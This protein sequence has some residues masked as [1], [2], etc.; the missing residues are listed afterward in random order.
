MSGV[1]WCVSGYNLIFFCSLVSSRPFPPA[2]PPSVGS[3][4]CPPISVYT[5]AN[6]AASTP[7]PKGA[8]RNASLS[9]KKKDSLRL[10]SMRGAAGIVAKSLGGILCAL[11]VNSCVCACMKVCVHLEIHISLSH[12][13][14]LSLSLSLGV[15]LRVLCTQ[16]ICKT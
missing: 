7:T 3:C 15:R 11:C 6:N 1:E 9:D 14:S 2:R 5:V 16:A 10:P 8:A 12:A 13:R 4:V